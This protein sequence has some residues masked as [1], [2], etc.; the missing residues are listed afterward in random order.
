MLKKPASEAAGM[1]PESDRDAGKC[2]G[3][4]S[5]ICLRW[6]KLHPV[7]TDDMIS[8]ASEIVKGAGTS[9]HTSG[10]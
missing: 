5:G 6:V 1:R 9:G 8:I 2:H 4:V 10:L 3:M 7:I